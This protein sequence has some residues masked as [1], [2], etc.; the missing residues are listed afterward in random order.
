MA[1]RAFSSVDVT[2][3][4]IWIANVRIFVIPQRQ[5][6]CH[7]AAIVHTGGVRSQMGEEPKTGWLERSR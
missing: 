5:D 6:V 7:F 1:P 2:T 4:A 3:K